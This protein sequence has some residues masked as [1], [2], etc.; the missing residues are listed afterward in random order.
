MSITAIL[1]I[2]GVVAAVGIV[3]WLVV[4]SK[5]SGRVVKK[6]TEDVAVSKA[7]DKKR[8]DVISDIE[9]HQ[10]D[11]KNIVD[12][13]DMAVVQHEADLM[14]RRIDADR[15]RKELDEKLKK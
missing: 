1:I 15:R 11:I 12:E 4:K 13:V 8:E 10:E 14:N 6:A 2:A 7:N 3:I 5:L 9:E